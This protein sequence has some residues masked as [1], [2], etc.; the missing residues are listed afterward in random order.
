[1][2]DFSEKNIKIFNNYSFYRV[3]YQS[4]G[5]LYLIGDYKHKC[6]EMIIPDVKQWYDQMQMKL[7]GGA[8][9]GTLCKTQD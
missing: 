3:C 4:E 2:K 6:M 7:K 9:Y 5:K 1:M 8:E